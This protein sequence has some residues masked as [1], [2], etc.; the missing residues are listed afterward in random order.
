MKFV[1]FKNRDHEERLGLYH[2]DRIYDLQQNA[3][4][5]SIVLPS[6]MNEFLTGEQSFMESARRVHRD[7]VDGRAEVSFEAADITLLAPVP[8]PPSCRDA[9]AFRQHVATARRNRGVDMIPEFDQFPVFYFTNHNSIAGEGDVVVE[10]D[11][12]EKL[13]FELEAAVVIG[14]RGRN[15]P[16]GKADEF[17]AGYTIMNDF[18][19]RLLQMEEMKLNLGPAKGKDFATTIGPWLV[20]PDELKAQRIETEF[21]DKYNLRMTAHH[22]GE[23]ISEGNLKDMDW[24]FAEIIERCSYG[25]DIFPGDVIGSGTVGTGCYLELN[26]SRAMEAQLKNED[27]VP[28]WLKEGDRMELTIDGLGKLTNRIV[29]ASGDHSILARRKNA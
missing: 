14:R 9:Y 2:E 3:S 5:L 27:Y 7:V 23:L 25:A 1:S 15:I 28:V 16:S 11:H 21:G 17:V 18:S 22:N 10:S 24:T 19:A 13:D 4:S 8:H 6:T 12:L 20:T 26:G 29:K